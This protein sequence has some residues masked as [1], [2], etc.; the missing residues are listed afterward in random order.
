M[1]QQKEKNSTSIAL[2]NR[3]IINIEGVSD[4]ISSD[5]S[6]IYLD[7]VDGALMIDGSD[8]RIISMS[9]GNK[10]MIIE[11]RIDALAYNDKVQ[12]KKSGFFARMLK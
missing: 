8:L 2:K 11:G 3:A 5:E 10:E 12:A 1:E 6:S 9:T 4:I 7:T